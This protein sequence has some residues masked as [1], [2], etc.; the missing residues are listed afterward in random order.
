MNILKG[1]MRKNL[2]IN[3]RLR[4]LLV[5]GFFIFALC[6]GIS[7]QDNPEQ[8]NP[9]DEGAYYDGGTYSYYMKA[10]E[11]WLV[12]FD[13]AENDSYTAA[14]YPDSENYFDYTAK[15]RIGI[16]KNGEKTFDQFVSK[17]SVYLLK[18]IDN[19]KIIRSDTMYY[20]S[21]NHA[22]I[23]ETED[24]GGAYELA[25][26]AYIDMSTET[27]VYELIISSREYFGVGESRFHEALG[28]FEVAEK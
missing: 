19:L 11:N 10:P 16:F 23:F 12:D 4:H 25:Q 5:N 6:L 2:I 24:P 14:F 28:R 1:L 13:N 7:A 20:S 26:V 3:W 9:E 15:I 27:V 8:Y 17:D 21:D 18:K 22:I